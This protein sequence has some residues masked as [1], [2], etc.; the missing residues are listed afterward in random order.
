MGRSIAHPD[1]KVEDV[2]VNIDKFIFPAVFIVLDYE[3]DRDVLII[4]GRSFLA[5]GRT[6]IDV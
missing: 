1:E 4:L 3:E 2:L 6:L 5:T